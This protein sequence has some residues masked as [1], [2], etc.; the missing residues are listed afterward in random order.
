MADEPKAPA[1]KPE[2]AKSEAGKPEAP[3]KP[4]GPLQ[5]ILIAVGGLVVVAGI[6]GALL[7]FVVLPRLNPPKEVKKVVVSEAE[8][9]PTVP[10]K[11][12]VINLADADEVH[13]LKIGLALEMK[14]K[15]FKAEE[16]AARDPQIRDLVITEFSRHTV[17]EV[18]SAVGREHI[19]GELLKK[20]NDAVGG[21]PLKTIYFTE[22]VA[23]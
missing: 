20:L 9:G 1:A 14:D 18:N 3:K 17:K 11:D 15:K 23:Q 2:A 4:G 16:F 21:A 19:R 5:M 6:A 22:Y 12:M 7:V 13:Y 10:I 8:L